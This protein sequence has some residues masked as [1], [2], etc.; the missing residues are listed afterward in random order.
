MIDLNDLRSFEKV[1]ATK[2]FASAARALG[3][4]RLT[5]RGRIARFERG[6]D[7]RFQRASEPACR[8]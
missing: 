5:V 6:L 1:A 4:P 3:L 2:S 7:A 8:S